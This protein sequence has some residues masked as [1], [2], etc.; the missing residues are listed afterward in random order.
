MAAHIRRAAGDP[1]IGQATAEALGSDLANAPDWHRSRAVFDWVK[2]NITFETDERLLYELLGTGPDNELLIRPELLLRF[3]RGDCDD[4][5][6]LTCA[7]LLRA[8]IPCQLVTIAA[9]RQEPQRF[10]HVY[11]QALL[12]GRV[13]FPM[14]TSHG[15]YAGWEAGRPYRRMEWPV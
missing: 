13:R 15:P 5:S 2:R 10:S 4:Y 11:A 14:D 12:D 6:M 1:A 8:G 7:M 9:D 3:R